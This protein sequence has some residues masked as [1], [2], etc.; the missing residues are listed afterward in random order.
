MRHFN[1]P[2]DGGRIRSHKE[3]AKMIDDEFITTYP[4]SDQANHHP[5]GMDYI[6]FG[7]KEVLTISLSSPTAEIFL[8]TA[9]SKPDKC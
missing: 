7:P 2:Y 6:P 9:S 5:V 1:L 4:Y 8:S 3:F